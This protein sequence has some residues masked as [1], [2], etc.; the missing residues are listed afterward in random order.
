MSHF[1]DDYFMEIIGLGDY[2]DLGDY[3]LYF[4]ER[5]NLSLDIIMNRYN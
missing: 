5:S 3:H 2:W 4:L 1:K